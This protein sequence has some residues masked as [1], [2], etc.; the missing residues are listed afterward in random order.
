[1]DDARYTT[2]LSVEEIE[3]IAMQE[4]TARRNREMIEAAKAR[5]IENMNKKPRK[6]FPWKITVI[7]TETHAIVGI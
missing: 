5:I 3:E 4:L 7:N 1:M 6:L 2:E